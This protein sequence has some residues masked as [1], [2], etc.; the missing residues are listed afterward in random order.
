MKGLGR[1]IRLEALSCRCKNRC[2][3]DGFSVVMDMKLGNGRFVLFCC[4]KLVC[5]FF[6]LF[7]QQLRPHFFS[8]FA[9]AFVTQRSSGRD[10]CC[11]GR[12]GLC[13][14]RKFAQSFV[15]VLPQK[16]VD[17]SSGLPGAEPGLNG[18]KRLENWRRSYILL[19]MNSVISGMLCFQNRPQ[20]LGHLQKH[21]SIQI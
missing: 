21:C 10:S 13:A 2:C 17:S 14:L 1:Y 19:E 9:Q 8:P 20:N 15:S 18:A 3:L 5:F 6:F 12:R 4:K 11:S 7:R 16:D